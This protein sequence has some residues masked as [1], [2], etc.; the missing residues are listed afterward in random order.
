MERAAVLSLPAQPLV[1]E[2]ANASSPVL[3][4]G[5]SSS[6]HSADTEISSPEHPELSEM[7]GVMNDGA[8]STAKMMQTDKDLNKVPNEVV[9]EEVLLPLEYGRGIG[10]A[11]HCS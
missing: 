5:I 2:D 8:M 7:E 3:S 10:L 6:Q 11:S 9:G 4:S 1:S